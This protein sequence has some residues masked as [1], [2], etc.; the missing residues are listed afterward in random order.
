MSGG[1]LALPLSG[2]EPVLAIEQENTPDNIPKKHPK[3]TP[4]TPQQHPK[5]HLKRMQIS[6][7]NL[8]L[9]LPE[10]EPVLAAEQ[11]IPQQ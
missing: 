11:E 8:A 3:N 4:T 9:P 10:R 5:Q 6:S 2:W 1:S 7:G